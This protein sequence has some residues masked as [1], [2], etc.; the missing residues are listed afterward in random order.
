MIL[1]EIFPYAHQVFV[2]LNVLYMVTA[3]G[4]ICVVLSEN[5]NPVKSLAWITVLLLLPVVG[6]ILYLF[7]GRSLKS[8]HMISR[9]NRK[10]LRSHEEFIPISINQLKLTDES[11][12]LIRLVGSLADNH[13]FPGNKIDIFTTGGK[14]FEALKRDLA[15]A[16]EYIHLQY[17]IFEDD[18]LGNE[19]ADILIAKAREGVRVRLI[20][21]H[22]GSFNLRT[23][24]FKRMRKA[25][26]EAYPFLKVTFPELANRINW[27]NHRKLV[28]VDG[29]VGYIGGMN[30]ADRYAY[31]SP[32]SP[33]WRD[34]HLR[35]TGEAVAAME[36]SFAV[37][38]NFTCH[39]LLTETTVHQADV[40]P[41]DAD[42]IQLV[43][44]DCRVDATHSIDS[45]LYPLIFTDYTVRPLGSCNKVIEAVRTFNDLKRLHHLD[46]WGVVDRDRR[47]TKEVQY[48]RQKKIFVPN[49]AEIENILMLED[50]IKT[51]ASH[52]RK[53]AEKTFETVK[54]RVMQMF[55]SEL[56]QQALMHVRHRVKL[57]VSKRIDMRFRNIAALETHMV[58]LVNEIKPR[59]TYEQLCRKFHQYLDTRDYMQV[60][61]VY[62]Q[63]Q[64]LTTTNVA[65]LCGLNGKDDYIKEVL[66]IL[67]GDGKEAD[68]IR[69]AVKRCFGIADDNGA[70]QTTAEA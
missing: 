16:C 39:Q 6:M 35:I 59:D 38:W 51:V 37:D 53:P 33:P 58:D 29:R 5:R 43:H 42:G 26:V 31:G 23:S 49:V 12:Q 47:D 28:I 50:V 45:R 57:E 67:K 15:A 44:E 63:K 55:A 1:A 19:I 20:Y 24:I 66:K 40:A 69:N 4:I 30:V 14:K 52:R 65:G 48:L 36:F 32:L 27:R 25:G 56:K 70:G 2:G 13:Y 46:S 22:V 8:V 54:Q 3:I 64:M 17:Y 7:F 62:N 68:T 10:K 41:D 9:R 18:T 21:D 34:T 11:K 61:R 60:L